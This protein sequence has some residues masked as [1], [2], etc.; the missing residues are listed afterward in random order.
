MGL[1][2]F[3]G[4]EDVGLVLLVDAAIILVILVDVVVVPVAI[5]MVMAVDV[6]EVVMSLEVVNAVCCCFG[7][8]KPHRPPP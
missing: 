2:S 7:D 8:F 1:G 5:I 3:I 6:V 4:D